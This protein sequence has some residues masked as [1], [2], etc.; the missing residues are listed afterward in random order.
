MDTSEPGK[1]GDIDINEKGDE[2]HIVSKPKARNTLNSKKAGV[3]DDKEIQDI[4]D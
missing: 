3:L 1:T 4:T 2:S